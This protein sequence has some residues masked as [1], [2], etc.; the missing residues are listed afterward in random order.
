M[1]QYPGV[2]LKRTWNDRVLSERPTK[3]R[4]RSSFWAAGDLYTVLSISG[5]Q[6]KPADAVCLFLFQDHSCTQVESSVLE[7]YQLDVHVPYVCQD[8]RGLSENAVPVL[9][10]TK[11]IK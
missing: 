5:R 2:S 6:K 4:M 1:P 10:Y 7:A 8:Q 3:L 11:L 9:I